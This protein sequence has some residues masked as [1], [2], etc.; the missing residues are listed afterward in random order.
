MNQ[1][2]DFLNNFFQHLHTYDYFAFAWIAILFI[3]FIILAVKFRQ[4]YVL[5]VFL[6]LI[7]FIVLTI[8]PLASN[9]YL[10]QNYLYKNKVDLETSKKLQFSK[11]LLLTGNIQNLGQENFIGCLMKIKIIK[12][13]NGYYQQLENSFKPIKKKSIL[14]DMNLSINENRKFRL[15]VEPFNYKKEFNI[16]LNAECY[17]EQ[18]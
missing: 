8:G 1:K 10:H 13:E 12:P 11:S 3:L 2:N 16:S 18:K 9:Y 17:G 4:K 14:L 7:G 5:A 15:L 6:T